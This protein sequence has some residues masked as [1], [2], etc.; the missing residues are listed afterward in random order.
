MVG[1]AITYSLLGLHPVTS[2]PSEVYSR[3]SKSQLKTVTAL[4][5]L[6]PQG[7]TIKLSA[8]ALAEGARV[9]QLLVKQGD[10]V[11]AGDVI[12]ILDNRERLEAALQQAQAE[13][14]AAEASLTQVKAGAKTGDI[15]AQD[16]KLQQ[17]K[18]ELAGQVNTQKASIANLEALLEGEKITQEAVIA[19]LV[20]ET[21]N[22][23]TDCKRYKSLYEDGA[24][25]SQSRDTICL[26]AE[27]NLKLLEE[28]RGDLQ[29]IISSRKEQIQAAKSELARIIATQQKQIQEAKASLNAIE[30]VRPVDVQVAQAN[31]K[32]AQASV[33]KAQADLA[34]AYVR[35]PKNS[36]ILKIHTWPGE[37]VNEQGI[38]ELGETS[39][40][41]VTAEVYETDITRIQVG[42]QATIKTNQII[43]DLKG[44]V[45]EIGLQIGK[46]DI[47]GTD[48]IA[49]IDARVVEVKIRLDAQDSQKVKGLTNLQVNTIIETSS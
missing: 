14:R 2:K 26:K 36:Q 17:R 25:S 18:A 28:A 21:R 12:A 29:R 8:S 1:S 39:Q 15:L 20:A 27:T 4:G 22:A 10:E 49:S 34:L 40:M 24:I 44:T 23:D 47:L 37:L 46:K 41:Y 35:A 38:V 19:R 9:E 5:R 48:P 11:K 6:E 3:E 31:L 30:E 16:A 42:Q 45:A 33:Q 7:E 13:V 43:G 32:I